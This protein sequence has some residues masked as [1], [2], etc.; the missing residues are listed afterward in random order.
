MGY[1]IDLSDMRTREHS[2]RRLRLSQGH[3]LK[4][5]FFFVF[6]LEWQQMRS[7]IYIC[8]RVG[9]RGNMFNYLEYYKKQKTLVSTF[10]VFCLCLMR[11]G[12][13]SVVRIWFFSFLTKREKDA[14]G[15]TD[16][17]LEKAK[18]KKKKTDVILTVCMCVISVLSG[19][20][21]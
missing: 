8:T 17:S 4:Q 21:N 14:S 10:P 9:K 1:T 15:L 7:S 11:I 6:S 20:V 18:K 16:H 3:Q 12:N 19:L 5:I 2:G 13:V